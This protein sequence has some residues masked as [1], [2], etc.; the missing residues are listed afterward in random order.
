MVMTTGREWL[1]VEFRG[2]GPQTADSP[3]SFQVSTS[4]H[5]SQL[6]TAAHSYR[7]TETLYHK[8]SVHRA[9]NTKTD[10]KQRCMGVDTHKKVRRPNWGASR[11]LGRGRKRS[12][13]TS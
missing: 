12:L 3:S 11:V 8:T 2:V 6:W 9:N 7:C 5:R 4:D 1:L 10:V 13:P